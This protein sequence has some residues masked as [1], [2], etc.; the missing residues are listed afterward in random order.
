MR[1][2]WRSQVWPGPLP[3]LEETE[4]RVWG[5]EVEFVG[6]CTREERPPQREWALWR[7]VEGP[8]RVFSRV[9][10]VACR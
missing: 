9:L 8:S 7:S 5:T 1:Q 4:L 2:K 6:Q 10:I 3:E